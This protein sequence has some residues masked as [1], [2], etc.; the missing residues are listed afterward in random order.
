MLLAEG[1]VKVDR[2]LYPFGLQHLAQRKHFCAGGEPALVEQGV[3]GSRA[4][5]GVV[6]DTLGV[7]VLAAFLLQTQEGLTEGCGGH[8][9]VDGGG[10]RR[11]GG[12]GKNS[13]GIGGGLYSQITRH[14]FDNSSHF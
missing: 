11:H 5:G 14:I 8:I 13:G 7:V 12:G 3:E 2:V 1:E 9:G 4:E 6:E 10:G